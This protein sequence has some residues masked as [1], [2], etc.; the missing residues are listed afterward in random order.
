MAKI[1]SFDF[2]IALRRMDAGISVARLAWNGDIVQ[3]KVTAVRD[4]G[5]NIFRLNLE[6]A[7][8]GEMVHDDFIP[9]ACDMFADDW[10]EVS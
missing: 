2:G 6:Y 7:L 8:E 1:D 10:V 4:E 5:G 3:A 9:D